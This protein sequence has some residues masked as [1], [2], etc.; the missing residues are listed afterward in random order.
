M[1]GDMAENNGTSSTSTSGAGLPKLT[2]RKKI[3]IPEAFTKA[4]TNR[5]SSSDSSGTVAPASDISQVNGETATPPAA[6]TAATVETSTA[7]AADVAA[8]ATPAEE[9]D[10]AVV[11]PPPPKAEQP[12][13]L[14]FSPISPGLSAVMLPLGP[15][16][17]QAP[18]RQEKANKK[19]VS[20]CAVPYGM[21]K[22]DLLCEIERT[23]KH[24]DMSV[25][26]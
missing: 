21:N 2:P 16:P 22:Y 14:A 12:P 11:S 3:V 20:G 6:A 5:R 1:A 19:S 13:K 26:S 17:I 7:V 15:S 18:G 8:A 23:A 4:E 10:V 9:A 25:L 24:F